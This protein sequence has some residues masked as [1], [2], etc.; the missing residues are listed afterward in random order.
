M[1]GGTVVDVGEA[2]AATVQAEQAIFTSVRSPMGTGYQLIAAGRGISADERREIV[3]CAPSHGSLCDSSSTA[4]GLASFALGSGRRCVFL[5][6]SAGPEHTGRGGYRVYTHV[7]VME[8]EVFRLFRCDPFNVEATVSTETIEDVTRTPPSG[9]ELLSLSLATRTPV[10]GESDNELLPEDGEAER[11]ARVLSA[12]LGER[13]MLMVGA[14]RPREV[15]RWVLGAT[16]AALR[17]DLSVSYGLKF[18]PARRFQLVIAGANSAETERIVRDH[19][20]ELFDWESPAAP[21]DCPFEAWLRFAQRRWRSGR[22]GDLARLS[23][24]LSRDC[25]AAMLEQIASLSEDIERVPD[26]DASLLRELSRRHPWGM[27]ECDAHRRLLDRFRK[28]A[29]A[30]KEALA[31]AEQEAAG[32]EEA[33]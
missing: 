31:Q 1:D 14:P 13:R 3:Q 11:A 30:R 8:L 15:L 4:T 24:E 18:S 26:A 27:P 29:E 32:D 10:G 23:S 25:S 21:V 20:I 5:S 17:R 2:C 28:A 12:V 16:P 9:L 22:H 6:R 7:L 19:E 33:D